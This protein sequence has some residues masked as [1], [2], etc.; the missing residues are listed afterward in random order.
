MNF[1]MS[2]SM[3]SE[4]RPPQSFFSPVASGAADAMATTA[5]PVMRFFAPG[6]DGRLATRLNAV[7]AKTTDA[8]GRATDIVTWSARRACGVRLRG[9]G[10]CG[11]ALPVARVACG[12]EDSTRSLQPL[13]GVGPAG[14]ERGVWPI[15][16]GGGFF[17]TF[18][19]PVLWAGG[20][21]GAYDYLPWWKV[22]RKYTANH[23][24]KSGGRPLG[25]GIFLGGRFF[26]A[27]VP[28]KSWNPC[29]F[30]RE[31]PPLAS[32]A[33]FQSSAAPGGNSSAYTSPGAE[34]HNPRLGSPRAIRTSAS[35]CPS[36][37]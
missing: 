3:S 10:A 26:S 18:S 4:N 32:S 5:R 9:S 6:G 15:P 2:G 1:S 20:K 35:P 33:A 12:C 19:R 34:D 23:K 27:G 11:A 36:R 17:G 14:A 30:T 16:I 22:P 24:T 29:L 37:R 8:T 21:K 31:A 13:Q 28:S 7:G 25:C